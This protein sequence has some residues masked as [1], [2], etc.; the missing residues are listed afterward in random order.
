M[1]AVNV[2]AS[3]I[4]RNGREV[5]GDGTRNAYCA[6]ERAD[7]HPNAGLEDSIVFVSSG[8]QIPDLERGLGEFV[9]EEAEAGKDGGPAVG[10]GFEV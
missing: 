3:F 9:G 5:A 10:G 4:G 2:P 6:Q 1:F 8:R 7:G